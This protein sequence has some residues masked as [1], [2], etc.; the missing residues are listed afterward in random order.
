MIR[1]DQTMGVSGGT[2]NI[3]AQPGD[4]YADRNDA[5]NLVTRAAPAGAWTAVAKLDYEGT[6]QYHQ[7]GI[8]VYGDD[9]NFIKFGRLA[10]D[11]NGNGDE[12]FEFIS[13]TPGARATRRPTRPPTCRPGSR[14]T[15]GSGW[16]PTGRT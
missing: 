8:M 12:K 14:G 16:S 15:T 7:A 10:T 1:P 13:R 9:D 5:K 6:T 3:P 11:A 2:L 4:I